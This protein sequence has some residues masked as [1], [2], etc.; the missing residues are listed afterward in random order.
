MTD[1]TLR[2][3]QK[4]S[5]GS[6]DRQQGAI[7]VCSAQNP[8]IAHTISCFSAERDLKRGLEPKREGPGSINAL[9]PPG[10]VDRAAK[11]D[12]AV[13]ANAS[14]RPAAHLSK[15][16]IS[17]QHLHPAPDRARF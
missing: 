4:I 13:T 6:M 15:H 7:R 8:W 16:P 5:S 17:T 11:H 14:I 9:P 1:P 3:V 10:R 2:A 12:P